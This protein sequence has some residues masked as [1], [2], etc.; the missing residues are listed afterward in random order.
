MTVICVLASAPLV[1][2]TRPS[3]RTS[4]PPG[5]NGTSTIH[6]DVKGV[7]KATEKVAKDVGH[8][9]SDLAEQAGKDL[10]EARNKA[11]VSGQDAWI[12][13]KVKSE[14]VKE[15]FDPLHVH[16]D[17][18]SK[19]VTLSGTVESSAKAEGAVNAARVVT[20]VVDV[21]NHL[22]VAPSAR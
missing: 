13:T 16:V 21:K 8:A 19:V 15:G 20:G 6:D 14:L 9:T 18:D 1:A 3:E 22:F 17:T 2:C 11:G 10:D 4:P 7:A 5:G 12:T